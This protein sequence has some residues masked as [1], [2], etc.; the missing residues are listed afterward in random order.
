MTA[1]GPVAE[2]TMPMIP[3]AMDVPPKSRKTRFGP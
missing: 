3:L 2:K 1:T